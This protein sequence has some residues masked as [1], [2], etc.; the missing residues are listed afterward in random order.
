MGDDGMVN[1]NKI[2]YQ[3]DIKSSSIVNRKL[4]TFNK[5]QG[6]FQIEEWFTI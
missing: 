3:I 5:T 6:T 2:I 4:Q 1:N